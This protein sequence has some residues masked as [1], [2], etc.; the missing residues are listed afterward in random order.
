MTDA[1][2]RQ[3]K[4]CVPLYPHRMA[5]HCGSGALRDLV[6]WAGLGW[7]GAPDEGLV[8]GLGGGL[9][10]M[11]LRDVKA[12]PPIYFVGRN[13]NMELDFC[14]RLG[15]ATAREQT[16]DPDLGWR[17]V[18]DELAQG[19]P[20]MVHADIAELPYLRVRLSNTRH[21]IVI[22]GY[23][24]ARGIAFVA[25][26]DR[27][28]IQEVPLDALQR[29]RGSTGFP[30][31]NR[32]ATY[33]MRFPAALPDLLL[34]ARMAA[35]DAAA[36]MRSGTGT[37]F[38]PGVLPTGSVTG[39][40]LAGVKLFADD[41][42][43]WPDLM[44]EP[45]L[46]TALKVLP[47]FVEKAGTGGGLFRRLQADFCRDVARLTGNDMFAA[48]ATVA[49]ECAQGWSNLAELAAS[50]TPA[51]AEVAAAAA[52]LPDLEEAMTNALERAATAD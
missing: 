14:E 5:G 7:D 40:G 4:Q 25:D 36:N 51:F 44:S 11:Y 34:A 49:G 42:R 39:S 38:D 45:V 8:F 32:F 31:P 2:A 47:V 20:V 24:K 17:W 18:E 16:D 43:T 22:T 9:A 30:D 26:N 3:V 13:A 37:L 10:F 41:I 15:I 35:A 33:R 19:R 46:R 28:D 21:D 50:E 1:A 12:S 52:A 23:D 29:A 48:A 27:A 6:E